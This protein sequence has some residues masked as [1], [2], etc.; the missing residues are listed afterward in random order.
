[1]HIEL[2]MIGSWAGLTTQ[3]KEVYIQEET[4]NAMNITFSSAFGAY[5]K[6]GIG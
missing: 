2:C 4:Y 5:M 1:M 6:Q 3:L